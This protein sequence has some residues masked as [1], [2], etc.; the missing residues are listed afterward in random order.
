VVCC[1]TWQGG[2]MHYDPIQ[3]GALLA[4]II[5]AWLAARRNR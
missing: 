2:N 3:L 1:E 5:N 4:Y